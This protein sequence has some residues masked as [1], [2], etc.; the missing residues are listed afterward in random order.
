MPL[1]LF[2]E[3]LDNVPTEMRENYVKRGD[4]Y[5]LNLSDLE[6]HVENH[7]KPLKLDLENTR[8]HERKLL[9]ENGLT[10]ALQR[11]G[12]TQSGLD[13]LTDR[14]STRL[15]IETEAK[16]GKRVVRITQAGS[17]MLP[18]AGSGE[19]GRATLDDLVSEAVKKFPSMFKTPGNGEMPAPGDAGGSGEKTITRAEFDALGARERA[20]KMNEGFTIADPPAEKLKNRKLGAKQM[21]RS[22]F[23]KLSARERAAKMAGG[24]TLVE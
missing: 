20:A 4:K 10:A 21:L 11:A 24:F 12:V 18:M 5:Q 13:L 14:L 17:E 23:D 3:N 22:D 1:N 15:A 19:G 7:V 6:K 2:V 16:T 8:E 9:L